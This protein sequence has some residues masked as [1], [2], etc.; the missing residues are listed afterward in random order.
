M[1]CPAVLW[2]RQGKPCPTHRTDFIA[3][4]TPQRS[5][6][7]ASC[8]PIPTLRLLACLILASLTPSILLAAEA[9]PANSRAAI[10]ALADN[11]AERYATTPLTKDDASKALAILLDRR[12]A[13]VKAT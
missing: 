9:D 7:I 10:Q 8:F 5:A 1:A 3:S 2:S 6:M 11:H 12:I 4:P 13:E